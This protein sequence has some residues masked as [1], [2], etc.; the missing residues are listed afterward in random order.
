MQNKE[1]GIVRKATAGIVAIFCALFVIGL[2][3]NIYKMI[4]IGRITIVDSSA[5][6]VEFGV[7]AGL[8]SL[9]LFLMK[10]L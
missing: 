7:A 1:V 2:L 5:A 9:Y 10:K 4:A 6:F 8:Y 3:Y